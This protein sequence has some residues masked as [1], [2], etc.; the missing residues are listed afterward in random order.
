MM[1]NVPNLKQTIQKAIEENTDLKKQVSV[2]MKERSL[3][4][5]KSLLNA[6]KDV[7]GVKLLIFKGE[8]NVDNL[9]EM[10]FQIKGEIQDK[11][12]LIAGIEEKDKCA[13]MVLLS[14]QLVA[15]GLNAATLV[16]EAAKHIQGGG[17]GQPNFATAGGKNATGLNQ[18]IDT[19][20]ELV[21]LK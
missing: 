1:N 3:S 16:K 2:Y 4:L 18:A 13:L 21:G 9:K 5:K 14:D 6:A 17:G 10:A 12:C 15:G 7:N 20:L 19:V 8:G 11:F